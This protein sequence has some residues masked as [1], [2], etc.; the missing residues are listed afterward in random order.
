[1]AEAVLALS[2]W[3]E[4]LHPLTR[5]HADMGTFC[6]S[7]WCLDP[8]LIPREVDLHVVE[9]DEPPSLEDMAAPAQAVVPPHI[10]TLAYLLLVHVTRTVDYR[11]PTSRGDSDGRNDGIGGWTPAWLTRQQYTYTRGMPDMLLG[12]GRGGGGASRLLVKL[13]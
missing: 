6:L 7:A 2:A 9:P 3:V 1:M 11:R 10:N 12:S 13:A 5:S 4:S 8:T